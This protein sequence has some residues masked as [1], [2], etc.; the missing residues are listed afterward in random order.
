MKL[1][2]NVLELIHMLQAQ[3][4]ETWAVGGCVRDALLGI[5]P[6]DFDLCTSALPEQI[7]EVFADRQLVLAGVK[8][9]TVGIVTENG[10]VEITTFRT[11][12]DYSDS[13][14][15][16]WVRFVPRLEQDLARR[17]FTINAMAYSPE[18]GYRDP[19]G[20]QED[21][22]NK[23]LRCVGD[24][25]T[26][27]R[28]DALRILRGARFAARFGLTI[29]EKT[30][31]AMVQTAPL[32]KELARERVFDEL[33]RLICLTGAEMLCKLI[34]V[35]I[36]I[37]EELEPMVG[38]DQR[39]PHHAHDVFTHTALVVQGTSPVP[40]LRLAALLHDV[41][42]PASFTMDENGR[43]H[44][45]GHAKLSSQMANEI[46]LRLKAPTTLREDVVW[47]IANHMNFC[48]AERKAVRRAMSRHGLQRMLWLME[49]QAADLGGKGAEPI[50]QTL[51]KINATRQLLLQLSQEEGQ[52][53]LRRLAVKGNDLMALGV[54]AGP[55]LG[56]MLARLLDAVI[57]EEIPNEKEP[58]LAL[59]KAMLGQ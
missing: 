49:L 38:F 20:G 32:M 17:D 19:F 48:D 7:Q 31:N 23:V 3:G 22:K 9:G 37:I 2:L 29:E 21:L 34:P 59:A 5:E 46:L 45:R 12:G 11:E 8:H 27:F 54:P 26:R 35:L 28:E 6:H 13:R 43:G 50:T 10:V 18:Q 55:E 36:H 47:L 58:L 57:S 4:F 30:W 40:E 56:A 44:F 15:P 33:C 14:H 51:E 16:G 24:P 53:T 1:P 39:S 25:E 52:M 42:K 41:G